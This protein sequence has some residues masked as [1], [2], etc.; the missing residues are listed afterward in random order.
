M[1][2]IL[3]SFYSIFFDW[4]NIKSSSFKINFKLMALGFFGFSSN[5]IQNYELKDKNFKVILV[6]YIPYFN[7]K[8]YRGNSVKTKSHQIINDKYQTIKYL[9]NNG[10]ST[11]IIK[12]L[13]SDGKI[14]SL[15][16]NLER[17]NIVKSIN[18][19][20]FILKPVDC[21]WGKGI[22]FIDIKHDTL[23][24]EISIIHDIINNNNKSTYII[25]EKLFNHEK[26]LQLSSFSL[27]TLR[28]ITVSNNNQIIIV[29]ACIRYSSNKTKID[30][31]SSGGFAANVDIHTGIAE[32]GI[33]KNHN[34]KTFNNSSKGLTIPFFYESKEMVV[35]SHQLFSD[36]KSI[37]WDIAITML[38][39]KIIE[40]NDDWDVILPQKL[41]NK[42]IK[43]IVYA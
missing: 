5:D 40:C 20:Q 23:Y 25:E 6:E 28:L 2:Y 14:Y 36:I 15:N 4:K 10:I 18:K 9:N 11:S 41:L 37:G 17:T 42:G 32:Y 39:P 30:N 38:G 33:K 21:R 22:K 7:R 35:K 12:Y 19:G 31:W 16:D 3:N 1:L 29:F 26:L 8:K 43:K 27:N 34:P 13:I 24:K